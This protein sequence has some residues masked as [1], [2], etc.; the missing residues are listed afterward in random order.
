M[1]AEAEV[2]D[3]LEAQKDWEGQA[4]VEMVGKVVLDK[5]L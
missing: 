4:L 3:T 1:P 2:L 5:M